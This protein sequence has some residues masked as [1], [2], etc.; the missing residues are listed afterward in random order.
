VTE[1]TNGIALASAAAR[2]HDEG[3]TTPEDETVWRRRVALATGYAA[4]G[5]AGLAILWYARVFV[6]LLFGGLLLALCLES[7]ASAVARRTSM[8]RRTALLLV[9][10]AMGGLL[11]LLISWRGPSVIDQLQQLQ[12]RL[13]AAFRSL[14]ERLAAYPVAQSA[15]AQLTALNGAIASN[16]LT[17]AQRVVSSTTTFAVA[18]GIVVF[19]GMYVGA[20]PA[21]YVD[22]ALAMI[23]PARRPDARI[24]LSRVAHS[25]RWWL[26]AKTLSMLAVGTLVTVGLLVLGIPLAGTFGL[27]AGLLTFIPNVGPML[28]AVP[29]LILALAMSPG[30]ALAVAALFVSVHIIEGMALTPLLERR[31]VRLPPALTLAVQ[32][33]SA[34]MV[35][36]I[37]VALAAPLTAV[38]LCL[39]RD[40]F[41]DVE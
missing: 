30:R 22:G 20:E 5:V 26:V 3:R 7:L 18:L 23:P 37:G 38:G 28:S 35:G 36:P 2:G 41:Q 16:M 34:T 29:P 6:F 9:L 21:R 40:R 13:P 10:G 15:A 14:G 12:G 4:A 27:L 33:I 39:A 1:S 25:L 11:A 19:V 24:L 8:A 31:A 17:M 32:L